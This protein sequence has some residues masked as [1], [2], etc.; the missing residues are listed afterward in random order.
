MNGSFKDELVNLVAF[1][2]QLFTLLALPEES[3]YSLV[4]VF[5]VGVCDTE[6]AEDYALARLETDLTVAKY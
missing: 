4:V 3:V 5:E 1:D 2:W 6:I